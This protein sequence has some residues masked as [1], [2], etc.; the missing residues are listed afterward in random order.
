MDLFYSDFN[1]VVGD[2]IRHRVTVSENVF[3]QSWARGVVRP[4]FDATQLTPVT[5][6]HPSA[7]FFFKR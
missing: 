1:P 7:F 2:G 5:P 4:L 6:L 3:N